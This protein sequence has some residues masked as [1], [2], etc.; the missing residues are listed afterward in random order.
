[1]LFSVE[2]SHRPNACFG[3]VLGHAHRHDEAVLA[4]MYAVEQQHRQ[5]QVL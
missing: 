3:A 1:M 5:R 4:H 2:P